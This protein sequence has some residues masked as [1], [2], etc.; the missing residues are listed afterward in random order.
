MILRAAL[1]KLQARGGFEL[2]EL[3][4]A[5]VQ[6]RS[7]GAEHPGIPWGEVSSFA[8]AQAIAGAKEV[9]G[10][11]QIIFLD[12]LKPRPRVSIGRIFAPERRPRIEGEQVAAEE[13]EEEV[14]Q[15][16]GLAHVGGVRAHG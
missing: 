16:G 1:E 14:G 6:D 9:D 10:D 12:E 11:G 2:E 15:R 4:V 7:D 13:T 8:R 3:V 5:K